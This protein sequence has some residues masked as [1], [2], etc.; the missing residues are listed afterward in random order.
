MSVI[1][2]VEDVNNTFLS[3]REITCNFNGLAGKLKKLEATD[4]ITKELKIDGKVVIPIEFKN[5][6]GNAVVT[7]KFYVYD[8]EEL[9]KKHVDPTIFSRIDRAKKKLEEAQAA[10]DTSQEE[11]AKVK[12][13]SPETKKESDETKDKPDEKEIKEEAKKEQ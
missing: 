10:K 6:V 9:A 3:R 7:G 8:D 2:T 4:M 13:T 11:N 1:E 12:E 5:H